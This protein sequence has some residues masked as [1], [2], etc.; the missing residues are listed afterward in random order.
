MALFPEYLQCFALLITEPISRLSL[1]KDN[2]I[3]PLAQISLPLDILKINTPVEHQLLKCFV[4]GFFQ[5]KHFLADDV[6]CIEPR[7]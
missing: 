5:L 3:N 1:I 7:G 2:Y 6:L 4:V